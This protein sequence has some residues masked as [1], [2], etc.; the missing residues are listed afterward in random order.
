MAFV[1]E[2][3]TSDPC[4]E[5]KLPLALRHDDLDL[6]PQ[7]SYP[8]YVRRRNFLA[9]TKPNIYANQ[10]PLGFPPKVRSEDAWSGLEVSYEDFIYVFSKNELEEVESALASFKGICM[11]WSPLSQP[12]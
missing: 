8:E 10:L 7:P 11:S 5:S 1:E 6:K 2:C 3:I 12:E 4:T 9:T